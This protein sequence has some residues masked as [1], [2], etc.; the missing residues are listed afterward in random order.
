MT[1]KKD[2]VQVTSLI[3]SFPDLTPVT[4]G[5]LADDLVERMLLINHGKPGN[6]FYFDKKGNRVPFYTNGEGRQTP[7]PLNADGEAVPADEDGKPVIKKGEKTFPPEPSINERIEGAW[8]EMTGTEFPSFDVD[9]RP[10]HLLGAPSQAKSSSIEAAAKRVAELCGMNFVSKPNASFTAGPLDVVFSSVSMA[11]HSSAMTVAGMPSKGVSADAH[12][13]ETPYMEVIPTKDYVNVANA[14]IGVMLLDEVGSAMPNIKPALNEILDMKGKSGSLDLS[15]VMRVAASNL[16]GGAD[17]A[18]TTANPSTLGTRCDEYLSILE[19]DDWRNNFASKKYAD[20]AGDMGVLGF[21]DKTE[22]MFNCLPK[23][24]AHSR[25]PAPRGWESVIDY[26]RRKH[27]TGKLKSNQYY[28]DVIDG[29]VSPDNDVESSHAPAAMLYNEAKGRVGGTAAHALSDYMH[30]MWM[31]AQPICEAIINNRMNDKLEALFEKRHGNGLDNN[32]MDFSYQMSYALPNEAV[33]AILKDT[34]GRRGEPV[35]SLEEAMEMYM[36]N[37]AKGIA[38]IGAD[39]H[40]AR[41]VENLR[42]DLINRVPILR[43]NPKNAEE[44]EATVGDDGKL[45]KTAKAISVAW[46]TQIFNYMRDELKKQDREDLMETV[47]DSI[48]GNAT[49]KSA[50]SVG[51][52]A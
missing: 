19:Y 15:Y 6:E 35:R 37:F 30:S 49:Y 8:L 1:D 38:R 28:M 24:D 36:T 27:A 4:P 43:V 41:A 9:V 31:G 18:F 32:G 2:L 29:K 7:F 10:I 14:G 51:F 45:T 46:T 21:L 47:I 33:T 17:G 22:T 34:D 25:A 20:E 23:K 42:N 12:G 5:D 40:V 39:S 44:M 52:Y 11:G 13:N 26:M 16:G 48:S 3:K 50:K